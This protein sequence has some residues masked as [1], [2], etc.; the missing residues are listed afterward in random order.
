[1]NASMLALALMLTAGQT[2][3]RTFAGTWTAEFQGKTYVRLV[4]DAAAGA[5][6]GK[7]SL[8]NIQVDSKGSVHK[9]ESAPETF[10]PIFDVAL[11]GSTLSFARKES[12]DTDRFEL[13]LLGNDTAE[14][15]LILTEADRKELAESGATTVKPIRLT[16]RVPSR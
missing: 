4:L 7:I 9:A 12:R 11:R 8:G 16:K 15:R 2:G 6:S 3:D 14:L 5:P 13:N 1:M 10:T